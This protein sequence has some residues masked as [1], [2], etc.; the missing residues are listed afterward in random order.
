MDQGG[1]AQL[2]GL[3]ALAGRPRG[4]R[5]GRAALSRCRRLRHRARGGTRRHHPR[6]PRNA[7]VRRR[8]G[9]PH[10]E[11]PPEAGVDLLW[12][13]MA[14]HMAA[15][16]EALFARWHRLVATDGFLMFSGLGPDTVQELRALYRRLDWPPPATT[17]TDMHDW[18]DMLV[19]AR[20]CRAGDGHGAR[21]ADLAHAGGCAGRVANARGA[22]C[23]PRA[24]RD[25]AGA[26]GAR[27]W[28][29]R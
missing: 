24:S 25:C 17:F 11:A 15:E 28:H 12:A 23:T 20:F 6:G 8:R 19:A 16:P 4:P 1:S 5:P 21:G 27:A 9:K 22:T 26:A 29:M 3:V 14:L 10:F 18:G 13:N 2:G 7:V